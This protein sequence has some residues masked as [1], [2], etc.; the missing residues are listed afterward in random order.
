VA[1][2]RLFRAVAGRGYLHLQPGKSWINSSPR[3]S[4]PQAS[5][6]K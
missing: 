3:T 1:K 6:L 5:P 4:Q 2:I